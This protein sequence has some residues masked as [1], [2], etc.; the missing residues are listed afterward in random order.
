[1]LENL[2]TQIKDSKFINNQAMNDGGAIFVDKGK[3]T[4]VL[5]EEL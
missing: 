4:S 5:V 3:N 2:K 1:M